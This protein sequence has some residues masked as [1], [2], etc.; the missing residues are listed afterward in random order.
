MPTPFYDRWKLSNPRD[1]EVIAGYCEHCGMEY[2]EGEDIFETTEGKVHEDC[3]DE[4]ARE[5]ICARRITA[6]KGS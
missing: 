6:E 3:L 1:F 2:Y 5:Q 4:F